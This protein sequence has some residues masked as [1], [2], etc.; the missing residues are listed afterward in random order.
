MTVPPHPQ[1][2]VASASGDR[3]SQ[4]LRIRIHIPQEHHREPLISHLVSRQNLEVTILSAMLG[5]NAE[6]GGWFDLIL[7]GTEEAIASA[8]T[9]LSDLQV[10]IWYENG[11]SD[12]W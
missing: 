11:E 1:S 10:E 7:R 3:R 9:Y 12:G 5:A 6:G 8:L 2:F 4:G